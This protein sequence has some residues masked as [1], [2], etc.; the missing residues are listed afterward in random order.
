VH[1]FLDGR[2]TDPQGGID[3]I[4]ALQAELEKIGAGRIASL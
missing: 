2:D 4:A 1:A 3:F